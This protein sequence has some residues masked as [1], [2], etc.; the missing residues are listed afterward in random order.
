MKKILLLLL[1][2]TG[3]ISV[4]Q[5]IVPGDKSIQTKWIKDENYKVKWYMIKDTVKQ[6][7]GIIN[8]SVS[9]KNG[10][11]YIVQNVNMKLATIPWVD[12]TI[13]GANNIVPVYHSSYNAQ[14]NMALNYRGNTISGYYRNNKSMEFNTITDTVN[15]LYFDSNIYNYL[16][17]WLPLKAGYTAK[18]PVYDYNSKDKHGVVYITINNVTEAKY[19]FDDNT[20]ENVFVL[21]VADGITGS[22]TIYYIST[23]TRQQL[24][25]TSSFGPNKIEIVRVM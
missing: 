14:R 13:A 25:M 9:V 19:K 6:E 12:S 24:K 7:V 11:I 23:K 21:D 3:K 18:I 1:L 16:L 17:C 10:K 20:E 4:A 15:S 22:N 5:D 2:A 8:T